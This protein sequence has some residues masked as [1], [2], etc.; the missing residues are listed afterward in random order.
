MNTVVLLKM[1]PDVVEEL[2]VAADGRSLDTQFL[3]LILNERDNHAL[4]LALLLKERHGGKVAAVALD[5]P[6]VDEVLFAALA[7]GADRAIKVAGVKSGLGTRT[8]ANC[9]ARVLPTVDGLLP[10][11]FIV[12]GC[13]AIDDLD[14]MVAPLLA[15]EMK[16]PYLGLVTRVTLDS[17]DRKATVQKE[18]AGGVHGE[19]EVLLPAVLGIQA[20]E[21][22]PRYVP[23]AKVRAAMKSQTIEM[24]E[25]PALANGGEAAIRVLSMSKPEAAGHAEML[26]GTPE[27]IASK[28]AEVLFAR[29]VL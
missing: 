1:V 9:L 15:H 13:Q 4:E 25:V 17:A 6:E 22:P 24:A 27:Q 10:A 21:K 29:G 12:A 11:D 16:L 5:A 23:V 14:G 8:A 7:K 26:E 3:R 2:E 28:I 20:A 19:F 18:Y